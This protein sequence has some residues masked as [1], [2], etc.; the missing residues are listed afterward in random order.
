MKSILVFSNGEKIG[1]GLIKLSLLYE[2][3]KRLPNTEVYWMTNEGKT[4]Y[5]DRLKNIASQYINE[6]FEQA[7]LQF[8]FWKRISNKYELEN[9]K[10]N[11]I[12]DT[13]KA[14]MRTLALKRIKSDVF[15]SASARG[16]FSTRKIPKKNKQKK[17][18]L[19]DLYELLDL[20][21]PGK[22]EGDFNVKIPERLI[23]KLDNLFNKKYQYIGYAPGAGEKEKIWNIEKFI[24]VVRYFENQNYKSVFFLGPEDIKLNIKIKKF[25]QKALYPEEIIDDF[26]GPEIVIAC[27]K[28]LSCSLSNDSGVSHMLSNN[29]SPLIKLFGPKDP[30][31]FTPPNLMVQT[32]SSNDF[33]G[34][35]VNL[36]PVANVI[37]EMKKILSL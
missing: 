22:I 32:I 11:Y 18:Y 21:K 36:I 10:F 37:E 6:F 16:V 4:V 26:S 24:E 23:K 14:V 33:G 30:I 5:K 8:L 9:R 25:F 19:E 29:Y 13:Q 2:I 34:N 1:D 12:L 15:I 7:N 3:K 27:T 20:I 31:K 35:D 28:Y 17:Y